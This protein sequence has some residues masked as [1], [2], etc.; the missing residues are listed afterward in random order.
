MH[1]VTT[2]T[3]APDRT[4][5]GI[6]TSMMKSMAVSTIIR[7]PYAR[8]AVI[9]VATIVI[10]VN[11]EEPTAGT[12]YYRTKEVVSSHQEAVLPVV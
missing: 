12:P 10:A 1:V 7:Y 5:I 6:E 4:A 3:S 2:K 8:A 11:G 9:E